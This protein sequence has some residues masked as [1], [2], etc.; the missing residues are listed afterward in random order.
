[1]RACHEK[2]ESVEADAESR[3]SVIMKMST[4]LFECALWAV[5]ASNLRMP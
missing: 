5:S 2:A 3:A 4:S 1:M